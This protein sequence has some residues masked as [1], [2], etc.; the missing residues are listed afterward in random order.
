MDLAVHRLAFF[1]R[2]FRWQRNLPVVP[3]RGPAA[4][5]TTSGRT[6]AASRPATS[7]LRLP[8]IASRD[9]LDPQPTEPPIFTPFVRIPGDRQP[10]AVNAHQVTLSTEADDVA[11]G[12]R[13]PSRPPPNVM[14]LDVRA[15]VLPAH[16]A[17]QAVTGIH[18]PVDEFVQLG[19]CPLARRSLTLPRASG[20]LRQGGADHRSNPS[21]SA[22]AWVRPTSDRQWSR[23]ASQFPALANAATSLPSTLSSVVNPRRRA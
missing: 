3:V 16:P 13:P 11:G 19:L 8:D 23:I 17:A 6:S 2:R 20:R 7:P 15:A 12:R 4:D 22:T 10:T 21:R 5:T 14:P 9:L 1:I 18:S